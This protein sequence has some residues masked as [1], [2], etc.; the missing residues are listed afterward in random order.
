MLFFKMVSL[1]LPAKYNSCLIL[2]LPSNPVCVRSTF[3]RMS[4][5]IT[6]LHT[7]TVIYI[8]YKM[9]ALPRA[10]LSLSIHREVVMHGVSELSLEFTA[11][12]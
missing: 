9:T 1:R 2:P 6:E 4:L 5:R 3:N 12:S 10:L 7:G 11:M 8:S